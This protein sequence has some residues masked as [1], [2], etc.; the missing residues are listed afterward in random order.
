MPHLAILNTVLD[1]AC[2]VLDRDVRVDP[3]LI[4]QV[5]VIGSEPLERGIGHL[6]D[7][8]RP[9]V[10]TRSRV[11][12]LE[13]ELGRNDDMI[14]NR[15]K[16]FAYQ[17]LVCE[18]P[19]SLGGVKECDTTL[20]GRPQQSDGRLFVRCRT[21]AKAQPH[22]AKSDGRDLQSAFAEFALLHCASFRPAA[23]TER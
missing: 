13:A 14:A 9:A 23:T 1:G 16:S 5:D 6:P 10:Q 4:E 2:H 12:V 8:L 11:A 15:R 3:V 7:A 22:A 17:L 19:V 18:R 21:V 20:K